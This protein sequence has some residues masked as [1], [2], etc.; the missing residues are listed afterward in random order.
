MNIPISEVAIGIFIT[1]ISSLLSAAAGAYGANRGLRDRVDKID[2]RVDR[3]ETR[4]GITDTGAL[5]GNGLIGE[6]RDVRHTV[7]KLS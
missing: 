5:T 7:E 6:M 3:V 2:H 4:V 1:L